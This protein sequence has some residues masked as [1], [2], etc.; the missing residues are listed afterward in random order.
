MRL[1]QI[2]FL[3]SAFLVGNNLNGA[4][5][6]R[7]AKPAAAPRVAVAQISDA[8]IAA[9]FQE[10]LARSEKV[11]RNR[12]E[13]RVQNGIAVLTGKTDVIQ[14][15]G[16]A[17][18]MAKAAGARGVVNKIEVTEAARQRAFDQLAKGRRKAGLK[19]AD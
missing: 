13:I 16:T 5:P 14:H 15:K 1:L 18:R 2:A 7:P 3:L 10:R 17:T 12:F 8:Q 19:K 6:A 4:A 9:A 11:S